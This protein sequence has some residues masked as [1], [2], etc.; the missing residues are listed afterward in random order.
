MSFAYKNLLTISLMSPIPRIQMCGSRKYPYLHHVENWNRG[1]HVKDQ[2]S[3]RR[4]GGYTVE[5]VGPDVL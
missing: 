4:V 3:S 2:R 1:W 5:M